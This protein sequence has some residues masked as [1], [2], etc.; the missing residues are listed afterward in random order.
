MPMLT[1][2]QNNIVLFNA[3][4]DPASHIVQPLKAPVNHCF[5]GIAK[6]E[7]GDE[8]QLAIPREDAKISRDGDGTFFGALKLL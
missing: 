7:E 1:F 2:F 3:P 8:I 5:P 4:P 6:L